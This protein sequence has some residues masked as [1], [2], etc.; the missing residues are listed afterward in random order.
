MRRSPSTTTFLVLMV[1]LT[2]SG[3]SSSSSEWLLPNVSPVLASPMCRGAHCRQSLHL[4]PDVQFRGYEMCA[5]QRF[6]DAVRRANVHV[7]HLGGCCGLAMSTEVARSAIVGSK[8]V[9]SSFAKRGGWKALGDVLGAFGSTHRGPA[10]N[11]NTNQRCPCKHFVVEM[12]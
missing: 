4:S 2:P 12:K 8:F 11:I 7:L 5:A 6:G 10:R 9:G 1:T 3:I